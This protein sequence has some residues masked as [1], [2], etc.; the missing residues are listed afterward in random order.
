MAI[1]LFIASVDRTT[2]V[3]MGT[4]RI[5]DQIN[6]GNDVCSF[7]IREYGTQTYK[8][9]LGAEVVVELDSVK[10]YGGVITEI[11]QSLDGPSLIEHEVTCKDYTQYLD[12]ELVTERY[13]AQ[14]LRDVVMDIVDVYASSYGFAADTFVEGAD[15]DIASIAFNELSLSACLNK[16]AKLTGYYWYVDYDKEVHFFKRNEEAAPFALTDIAG[17]HIYESLVVREDI[18]QIRNR[19]KVRGGEAVG[20]ERTELYAGN[21]E[22]DTFPLG[23]KFSEMP[24]V[25]VDGTPVTVGLDFIDDDADFDAMW[26]FQQKYIRF[27]AGNIPG[28]PGGGDETNVAVTGTPLSPIVVERSDTASIAEFGVYEFT[29]YNDQILTRDHALQ[30]AAAEL[31]AYADSIRGGSFETNEPGLRSGQTISVSSTA[32]GISG[33]YVIQSVRFLQEGPEKYKWFVDIASIKTMSLLDILQGLL[34]E[35]RIIVGED[36]TLLNFFSLSD[37]FSADDALGTITVTDT[38]DYVYEDEPAVPYANAGVWNEST[39]AP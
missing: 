29:V 33:I 13:D 24:V 5:R 11:E 30:Y 25:E 21:G 16:L 8:P 10:I 28:L 34:L 9:V 26:N 4:L 17:N 14:T 15:V 19:V 35:E 38:E 2:L 31:Q 6:E 32:R 22:Q 3:K 1:E 12:R 23:S 18:N 27:T 37:G 39:W 20:L 36:Q 7:T